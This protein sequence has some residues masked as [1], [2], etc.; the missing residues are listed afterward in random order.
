MRE[1]DQKP[2]FWIDNVNHSRTRPPQRSL[3]S[4]HHGP[5]VTFLYSS[6]SEVLLYL[7]LSRNITVSRHSVLEFSQAF[8]FIHLFIVKVIIIITPGVVCKE[9]T[10]MTSININ[11][12]FLKLCLYFCNMCCFNFKVCHEIR[13]QKRHIDYVQPAAEIQYNHLIRPL[14][15]H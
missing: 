4:S 6:L 13:L 3:K 8:I 7:L 14:V 9:S 1:L 2:R 5:N 15:H 12:C 11:T 10:R